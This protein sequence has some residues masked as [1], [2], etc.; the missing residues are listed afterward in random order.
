MI[1]V[2]ITLAVIPYAGVLPTLALCQYFECSVETTRW[3]CLTMGL[4][5]SSVLLFEFM[6]KHI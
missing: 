3:A 5:I 2:A 1:W 6:R 4:G